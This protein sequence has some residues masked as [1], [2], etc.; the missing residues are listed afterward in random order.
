VGSKL[1]RE[2]EEEES[3]IRGLGFDGT[4]TQIVWRRDR[5]IMALR[6]SDAASE[7]DNVT[8]LHTP[9]HTHTH[10]HSLSLSLSLSLSRVSLRLA[11]L[12]SLLWQVH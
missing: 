10:T 1:P 4:P 7:P 12:Q 6:S 11:S 9:A 3:W 2:E 5:A 8:F